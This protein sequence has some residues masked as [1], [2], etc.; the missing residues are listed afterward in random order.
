MKRGKTKDRSE[1]RRTPA[2]KPLAGPNSAL[3]ARPDLDPALR[4]WAA[5]LRAARESGSASDWRL[6]GRGLLLLSDEPGHWLPALRQVAADGGFTFRTLQLSVGEPLPELQPQVAEHGP[7]MLWLP[8]G[9]WQLSRQGAD[10]HPSAFTG[11]VL[12]FQSALLEQLCLLPA[13]LP[14]V[15]IACAGAEAE[16]S[17]RLRVAG[18]FDRCLCLPGRTPGSRGEEFLAAVGPERC[19]GAL[20]ASVGKVGHLV[21]HW[22]G[23][24]RVRDLGVLR[25]QRLARAEQRLLELQDIFD[26][27]LRGAAEN[28]DRP[29][30]APGPSRRSVAVHEAGHAVVAILDSGGANFPDYCTVIPSRDFEG[31]VVG[32]LAY[33]HAVERELT[34]ERFRHEIRL[35]LAGRAAEELVFGP[36]RVSS[37]CSADLEFCAKRAQVAFSRLGFAPDPVSPG[38]SASNLAVAVGNLT[39][40]QQAYFESLTRAFLAEQY[41]EVLALLGR[42]RRLLDSV[43]DRL[44]WDPVVDQAEL[45][46]LCLESGLQLPASGT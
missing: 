23:D 21:G 37:G 45:R 39:P 1:S 28:A 22:L 24:Q 33:L 29:A 6:A 8:S 43:A 19:S 18:A 16:F 20:L 42:H 34:Q 35:S 41:R 17:E 44:V 26:L 11:E 7:V 4:A 32:S 46:Q 13:E 36:E 14:L 5:D 9:T 3:A 10:R 15:L 27:A 12:E 30:S 25:L 2:A 31:V 40:S 38:A